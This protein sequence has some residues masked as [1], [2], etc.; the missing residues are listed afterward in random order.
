MLLRAM[1]TAITRSWVLFNYCSNLT[2]SVRLKAP[3][4]RVLH[5]KL[6]FCSVST[7]HLLSTHNDSKATVY[8][9]CQRTSFS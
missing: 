9:H 2:A 5:N 7:V 1:H 8:S 6:S 3:Y 4:I